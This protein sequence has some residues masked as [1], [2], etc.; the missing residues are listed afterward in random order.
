MLKSLLIAVTP[1]IL[2]YLLQE[3]KE[4]FAIS[5]DA[6]KEAK[7]RTAKMREALKD[8]DDETINELLNTS[9]VRKQVRKDKDS[10]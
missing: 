7:K 5:W 1:V 10:N 4:W 8:N 6:A 3:A 9:F 2:Q